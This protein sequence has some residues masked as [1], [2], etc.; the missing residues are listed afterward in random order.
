MDLNFTAEELA[1]RASIREWV[2][3]NLPQ[4]ISYKVHNALR[5]SREGQDPGRQGL[6]GV[7]LAQAVWRSWMECGGAPP[8]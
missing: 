3:Q 7:E 4:D 1:F 5:L 8:V 2:S 6:A